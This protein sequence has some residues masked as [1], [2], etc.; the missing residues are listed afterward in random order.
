[1]NMAQPPRMRPATKWR[2][3]TIINLLT[4]LARE[5]DLD[6]E[7]SVLME[8]T[9]RRQTPPREIWRWK[10]TEDQQIIDLIKR[11]KRLGQPKPF[12]KN[13]EVRLL[14]AKLGRTEWAVYRR[15]ERLRKKCSN[16]SGKAKG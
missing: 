13:D 5:R 4:K 7:E 11:R 1:M 16:A 6:A 12:Q 15:M 2:D 8:R 3:Q 9:V 14:A 10:Q